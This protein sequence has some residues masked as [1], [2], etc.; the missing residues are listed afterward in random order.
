MKI[1]ATFLEDTYI[2][3]CKLH[4]YNKWNMPPVELVRFVVNSDPDAL[5]TYCYDEDQ[6]IPHKI[7]IS[8]NRLSYMLT[9]IA[10]TAH[11]MIHCSRWAEPADRKGVF[12]WEKHDS[13]FR[14]RARMVAIEF[15]SFD[16]LEL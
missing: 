12:G 13:K 1:N 10:T 9:C 4:P 14:K 7:T 3:L 6:E 11:E 15:G 5:G 2:T 8:R 16:P